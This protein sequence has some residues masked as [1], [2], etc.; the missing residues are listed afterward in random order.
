MEANIVSAII[1]FWRM[2]A[3]VYEIE[4]ITGVS[5]LAIRNVIKEHK[6][7]S[8]YK[9]MLGKVRGNKNHLSNLKN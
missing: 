4:G 6:E 8:D 3:N 9:E 2:G 5:E 7:I 1:G